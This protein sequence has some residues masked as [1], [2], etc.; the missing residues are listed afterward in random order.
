MISVPLREYILLFNWFY[1][2][3]AMET[4][5]R[6]VQAVDEMA[7]DGLLHL[8]KE[9]RNVIAVNHYIDNKE[10]KH[11][12]LRQLQALQA[13]HTQQSKRKFGM[14]LLEPPSEQ[15]SLLY[16]CVHALSNHLRIS[17]GNEN[18]SITDLLNFEAELQAPKM[19]Q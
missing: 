17:R 2:S 13:L 18:C 14:K 8:Q 15:R 1:A 19:A 5:A 4:G 12:L 6:L 7:I 3:E 10:R 16:A 9:I 11:A